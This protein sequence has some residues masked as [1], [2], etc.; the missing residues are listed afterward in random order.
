M[1]G[2]VKL[3]DNLLNWALQQRGQFPYLPE[4]LDARPIFTNAIETFEEMAA[5]KKIE[6]TLEMKSDFYLY[7]DRNTASAIFRNLI[8]NAI[9]FT[10]E[11]GSVTITAMEEEDTGMSLITVADS[12][13]G[14][15]KERL[16]GLFKL[17]EKG[18]T[19]GTSGEKGLG[20]GL[21]LVLEFVALNKGKI[22]VTSEVGKGTT[23]TLRLPTV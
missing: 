21:Q 5:S 3:L 13:V 11:G 15:T 7:I 6:L 17:N 4:K 23:F 19:I 9:K 12:G 2:L 10:Q 18:S 16:D 8:N 1:S 14:M 20:L 22:D